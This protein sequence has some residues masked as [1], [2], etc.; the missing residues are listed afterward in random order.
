MKSLP[1]EVRGAMTVLLAFFL[2]LGALLYNGVGGPIFDGLGPNSPFTL[3]SIM[4]MATC[5][6]ALLLGCSGRL[7]Q[8]KQVPQETKNQPELCPDEK[9]K[10]HLLSEQDNQDKA[11]YATASDDNAEDDHH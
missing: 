5:L 7:A 6:F 1:K 9:E 11:L 3:V 10:E 4:D 2:G 8:S